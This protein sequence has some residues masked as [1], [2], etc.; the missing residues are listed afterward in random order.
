MKKKSL[1]TML[2][3]ILIVSA[4]S[5]TGCSDKK[6]ADK[7]ELKKFTVVLDWYPNAIHSFIYNAIEKGYYEEEGLDVQIQFPSG[8]SDGLSMTA[9]G[10]AD[11]GIYYPQYVIEAIANQDVPVKSIGAVVQEPLSVVLSLADKNIKSPEDLVGKTIGASGSELNQLYLKTMIENVGKKVS[12][13]KVINVG[14]DLMPAMTTGNVDA[15]LGCMINHEVPQMEKEG[16]KV[17]YFDP[18]DY[19]VPKGYELVFVTGH[20]QLKDEKPELKAFLRASKKGFADMKNDPVAS[21]DLML[22]K[23]NKENFPLDKNVEKKSMDV[24]IPAMEHD[25]APFLSQTDEVWQNNIDWLKET[26]FIKKNLKVEDVYVN[27][28]DEK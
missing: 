25:D 17:N 27:L 26:K 11:V 5:L 18:T 10:K 13:M 4:V 24:L 2:A 12:D 3:M 7:K 28:L 20:K 1:I 16:Y 15:T 9:A 6:E 22:E 21:L 8:T 19:G 23:Q 14:F